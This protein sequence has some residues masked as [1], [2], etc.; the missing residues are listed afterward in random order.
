MIN[1]DAFLINDLVSYYYLYLKLPFYYYILLSYE[2]K[3]QLS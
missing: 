3:L 1:V 2:K